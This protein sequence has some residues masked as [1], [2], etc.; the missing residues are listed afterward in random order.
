MELEELG[1]KIAHAL[2]GAVREARIAFG[3]L[4]VDVEPG[5]IARVLTELA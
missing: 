1:Q 2:P 4:T 3:E 5:E